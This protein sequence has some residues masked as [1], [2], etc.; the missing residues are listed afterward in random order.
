MT[1]LRFDHFVVVASDVEATVLF[2][3]R[4]CRAEVGDLEKW[5]A[6]AAPYPVVRF[7][8]WK[9]NVHPAGSGLAPAARDARPG[10]VDACFV[11]PG[12]IASALGHLATHGVPVELGP[13]RQ[14]GAQGAGASVYF[15]DPDGN[16]LELI[17]YDAASAREAREYD[18]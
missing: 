9:I 12:P 6:G 2:Y 3:E 11:W 8:D 7:G 13:I 17:S 14:T 1:H 4:V 10:A 18:E 16:L 15:R 5:R